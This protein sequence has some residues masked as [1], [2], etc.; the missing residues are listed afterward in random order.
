[1]RGLT[2]EEVASRKAHGLV[3]TPAK[4]G[5][6]STKQIVKENLFTYYNAIF[7]ILALMLIA[8]GKFD[9]LAFILVVIA[10]ALIGITQQ[11]RSKKAVDQLTILA[12][13]KV[14]VHRAAGILE[15]PSSE[16]VRDDVVE[17]EAGMQIPAD[18]V[19]LKD[20][21]KVNESLLTGEEDDIERGTGDTLHS[22]SVCTAGKCL[23]RLT[24]VGDES[25]ASKLSREATTNVKTAKSDMM[26]SLDRMI[27][28]IGILL[29]P[30]G[31]ILF[32]NEKIVLKQDLA[33]S[34]QST[35]AALVGMIPEGLYLLTS[36]ALAAS[37][38]RLS[39]KRVLVRDL[40]CVET[41][42]RIDTL[43]VDKTGTITEPGMT[44]E[45]LDV[46]D[47]TLGEKEIRRRL[48]TY[49]HAFTVQNDT[50]RALAEAFSDPGTYEVS[51]VIPFDS[52]R[53]YSAVHLD[54]IGWVVCGALQF[55]YREKMYE[56]EDRTSEYAAKGYRVLLAAMA[57]DLDPDKPI[58]AADV[59]P[60]AFVVLSNHVRKSAPETFAYFEKQG[61]NIKVISGD[62][63]E[64]VSRIA[65]YVGIRGAENYVDSST[66]KTDEELAEA[67]EKYTVFGRTTPDQKKKMVVAMQKQ[68]HHV[69][70]TGD[71][72]NDVLALKEADCG[73]AMA[74][75]SDAASQIAQLVLLD[76]DFAAVPEIVLEGRRV[77]NNIERSAQL[78]LS[79]NIF[80]IGLSILCVVLSLSYPLQPLQLSFISSLCIGIPGFFLAMQPNDGRIEG[81]F[82][83]NVL[84][85]AFPGG[86]CEL[87]VIGGLIFYADVFGISTKEANTM[88]VIAAFTVGMVI[89]YEA[90]RPM[91][92]YRWSVLIGVILATLFCIFELGNVM[93]LKMLSLE[94]WM[95]LILFLLLIRPC[96]SFVLWFILQLNRFYH[97]LRRLFR[98]ISHH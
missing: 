13:K 6:K 38:L 86:I 41:L 87:L 72:V 63:A 48:G 23:A 60:V 25:Y 90:C 18:A 55:I 98:R 75:G 9:Q 10:N 15:I 56:L 83:S 42:A 71:G 78:F 92:K 32:Y 62:D 84:Y 59:H 52:S 65:A 7:V 12:E 51:E 5:T 3:N 27:M 54:G 64:T 14:R 91:N 2:E 36:I 82:L 29:I 74:S 11:L 70:M 34:V 24:A 68:G 4:S 49:A 81:H 43:C 96:M 19:V 40:N 88:A 85:R 79:K 76:S 94:S 80:S 30:I 61:V 69:A 21:I 46:L 93:Q 95:I 26:R 44:V 35:V 22:G 1:M 33:S 50:G 73:I 8:V 37:V 16:L 57:D 89:L 53:K 66:L 39:Q 17:I 28:V 20:T 47:N 58:R 77:I 31:I 45:K 67:V 97:W